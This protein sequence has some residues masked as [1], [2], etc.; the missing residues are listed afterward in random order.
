MKVQRIAF[1]VTTEQQNI[2]KRSTKGTT[3]P[4]DCASAID[5]RSHNERRKKGC[6]TRQE[7]KLFGRAV[8]ST[9]SHYA[10]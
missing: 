3:G 7:L 8:L 2:I 10:Y 9:R 1:R 6:G 5:A 4:K